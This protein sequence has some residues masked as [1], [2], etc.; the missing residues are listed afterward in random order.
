EVNTARVEM[1]RAAHERVLSVRRRS[2]ALGELRLLLG[3]APTDVPRLAEDWKPDTSTPPPLEELLKQALANRA[4]VKAARAELDAARAEVTRASREALPSPRVGALYTREEGMNII[5]GTLG[6]DLPLFQRNQA[7]RGGASARL[8]SAQATLEATEQRVRAEVALA[9]ER[10][11]NAR[12]AGSVYSAEVL[13]ALQQNLAL[14]NEAYRAGKVDFF[15]LLV[16]RRDAL[17]ARRG[18]IDALEEQLIAEA[19]LQGAL[20]GRP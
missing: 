9:L 3:L 11:Q 6:L 4:E 1:G 14:V 2:L 16:I 18:S 5:Q 7:A 20:G 12:D 19:Q 8:V 10:Y 13:E 15:Q 17:D